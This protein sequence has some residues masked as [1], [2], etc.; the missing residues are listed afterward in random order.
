MR[1]FWFGPDDIVV[2]AQKENEEQDT[3]SS[4]TSDAGGIWFLYCDAFF[5]DR[6]MADL[7]DDGHVD[8]E[9]R[10]GCK[11]FGVSKTAEFFSSATALL[12]NST[13]VNTAA[14]LAFI[15]LGNRNSLISELSIVGVKSPH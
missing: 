5:T 12:A 1:Q 11:V 15:F 14:T 2:Y 3:Q 13:M 7:L 4:Q 10:F 6:F 9:R 8:A